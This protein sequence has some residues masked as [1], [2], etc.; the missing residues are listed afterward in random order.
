MGAVNQSKF[1][2]GGVPANRMYIANEKRNSIN[3]TERS[4]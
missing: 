2:F 3:G 1:D 4:Q